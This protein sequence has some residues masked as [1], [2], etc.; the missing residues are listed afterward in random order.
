M[1]MPFEISNVIVFFLFSWF[2]GHSIFFYVRK[3]LPKE[4]ATFPLN[5]AVGKQCFASGFFF[6]LSF[7]YVIRMVT[8][9]IKAVCRGKRFFPT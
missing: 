9:L 2:Y 7:V 4:M 8:Q 6:F 3:S 1:F 5:F